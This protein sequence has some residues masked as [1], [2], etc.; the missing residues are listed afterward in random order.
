VGHY[1]IKPIER[2]SLIT[3]INHY[4]SPKAQ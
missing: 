3:L 2:E 1:V 4:A